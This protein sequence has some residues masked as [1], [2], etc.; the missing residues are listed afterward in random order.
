MKVGLLALQGAVGLHAEPSP[1]CGAD[2]VEVRTPDQLD[3]STRWS[4][5]AA[6]RRPCRSCSTRRA[7]PIR[8]P[9]GWPT[10]CRCFGTCAGMILLATDG[11]RRPPR[12][13]RPRR[14]RHRPCAATRFGR[15]VD[16]FEADLDGR[17]R[18]SGEPPF[19]A[20]FIRAPVIERAGPGVEVLA[21]RRRPPGAVPSGP[22]AGLV[23]PPRAD[24]RPPPPRAVPRPRL[25]RRSTATLT[26]RR[27]CPA[28]PNG[29]RSSTRRAPPTRSA[30]SSSPS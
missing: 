27:R 5:P 16:S 15:Q 3:A 9:S 18:S 25:R 24:R 20:V 19:H 4:C 17:R 8:S 7:W 23:V 6:S 13:A 14:D 29:Q 2:A 12:P 10:A 21:A 22:G 11:P 26:R 1:R 30:A 28:I